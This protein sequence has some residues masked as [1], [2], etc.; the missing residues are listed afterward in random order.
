MT[1]LDKVVLGINDSHDAAAALAVNGKVVCALSEERVQRI[2]STGGLPLGAIEACLDYAGLTKSDIDYVAVAGMRAVPVNLLGTLSTFTKED[3]FRIQEQVRWPKFYEG[4]SV[5]LSEIFPNYTPKGDVTYPIDEFPLKESWELSEEEKKQYENLRLEYISKY[6]EVPRDRILTFDHHSCHAYYAY[7][8]NSKRY[9]RTLLVLTMDAGGDGI[10]DSVCRFDEH[11]R[12]DRVHVSHDCILGPIYTA[13]TLLLGMRPYEHEYKVMGLAPYAKEHVK[14]NTRKILNDFMSLDGV[15]F[16]RNPEVRDYFWYT[17]ELLRFE[18][19]DGVAGGLQDF[20]E[21]FLLQWLEAA[22][23]VTGTGNVAFAGGVALNVKANML[24][25]ELSSVT[26]LFV[27]PGAG[28]ESLSIGA[29][30]MLMDAIS[31]DG[32]HREAIEPLGSAYLGPDFNAADID[33]FER[34]PAVQGQ[35]E[36]VE[37]DP[38]SLTAEAIARHHI[39][40]VCQGRMEFGPRSLGHRSLICNPRRPGA[41][42]Q[43]NEAIKGRDFWMPFAPSILQEHAREYIVGSEKADLSFMT[44]CAN[45]TKKGRTDMVATV[46]PYDKTMRPQVVDAENSGKYHQ[47]LD[48]IHN[49]TGIG[50]VLNTSLNIH[51]KPIVMKPFDIAEELLSVESVNL[52]HLMI[53]DRFYR[54]KG[55]GVA[56]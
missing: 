18:R 19:F 41:V 10:Y 36:Q 45:S 17:K 49:E 37:G 25:S 56:R 9:D 8:A 22:V 27:P 14:A 39:V 12:F 21:H 30:W 55:R 34:H 5:G 54:R 40:G 11:G 26:S 20:A 6:C 51:G 7:Y 43:I 1:V 32:T 16:T 24:L 44:V 3:F 31:T 50:G 42:T 48:R 4:K 28:D 2:K 29:I 52:D 15:K 47:V 53:D 23:R 38:V 13:V 35:F 46:H 33:A